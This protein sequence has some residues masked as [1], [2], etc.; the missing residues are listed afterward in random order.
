MRHERGIV[1]DS[2]CPLGGGRDHQKQ[3]GAEKGQV[4]FQ[5]GRQGLREKEGK[6]R[7]PRREA[8]PER[9]GREKLS[10][11]AGGQAWERGRIREARAG[12]ERGGKSEKPIT[13]VERAG[14]REG[15]EEREP[16]YC[17]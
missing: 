9:E 5:G 2:P 3:C 17:R 10:S 7:L 16:D 8:R 14:G 6:S 15:R 13:A 1:S 11:R 4:V 12:G